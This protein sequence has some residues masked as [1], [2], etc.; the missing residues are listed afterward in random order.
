MVPVALAGGLLWPGTRPAVWQLPGILRILFSR[1]LLIPLLFMMAW[2]AGTVWLGWYLSIWDAA[3][4]TTSVLWFVTAGAVLF[5]KAASQD[6]LKEPRFFR[7]SAAVPLGISALL[8]AYVT[9]TPLPL[10]TELLLQPILLV[11]AALYAVACTQKQYTGCAA[12]L[13][14]LFI[15]VGLGDFIYVTVSLATDWSTTN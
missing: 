8:G 3:L 2:T 4:T 15:G 7:R 14:V 6:A 5:G 10:W 12:A 1:Q 13:T 9:L 11:A